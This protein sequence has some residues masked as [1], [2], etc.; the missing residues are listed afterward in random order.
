MSKFNLED[1][2]KKSTLIHGDKYDYS[3]SI[4]KNNRTKL[5]I[6]CPIHGD[7]LQRPFT[8]MQGSG[9]RKCSDINRGKKAKMSH[10]DFIIKAKEIH[11]DRYDYSETIFKDADKD[12]TIICPEHG[13]FEQNRRAHLYKRRGCPKCGVIESIQKRSLT[14]ESFIKKAKDIHGDKYDYSLVNYVNAHKKVD[15]I[16]PEHGKFSQKPGN[17][18]FGWGC[19]TCGSFKTG[20]SKRHNQNEFL[21]KCKKIHGSKYDY[22][23]TEYTLDRIK[24][25]ITCPIHGDFEQVP[26]S[27]LRGAGCPRCFNKSEGQVAII[28]NEL[29]VVH[30]NYNIE[31]KF[32]DFF[33]PEKNLIIERDG[34]QHYP[35][36]WKR[37]SIFNK[38]GNWNYHE[39][40]QND[41]NKVELAKAKNITVCRIPYWLDS[42]EVKKEIKNI[43]EFRPSYPAIPDP[44]DEE[45]LKKPNK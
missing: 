21:E 26:N 9:C 5:I 18:L 32:F 4:Y 7:F 41:I 14:T 10:E 25:I 11:G 16:C 43:L 15:I 8:H 40:H 30:R 33:L 6:S 2:L 39:E 20:A 42:D 35:K 27:H 23:K 12:V 34:E 37:D 28:L 31:N 29:F 19:R 17:H 3:K 36:I 38:K 13:K 45:S 1:F 44:R 24:V 22:S